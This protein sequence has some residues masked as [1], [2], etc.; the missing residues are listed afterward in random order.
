MCE[1]L[2]ERRVGGPWCGEV[3]AGL[4]YI[5]SKRREGGWRG[6]EW[7]AEVRLKG[8]ELRCR[9]PGRGRGGEAG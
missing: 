4:P 8:D 5:G 7:S 6:G 3:E 1:V 9:L 2:G